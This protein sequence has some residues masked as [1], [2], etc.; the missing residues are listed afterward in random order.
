M[1]LTLDS[2]ILLDATG[3]GER[4]AAMAVDVVDRASRSD[5]VQTLQSFSEMFRVLTARRSLTA[6][7]AI[8]TKRNLRTLFALVATN[9]SDFRAATGAVRDHRLSFRDTMLWATARR[10]GC[11]V[12]RTEDSQAGRSL[13]GVRF[14]HPF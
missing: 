6:D 13:G 9:A 8:E 11:R 3:Q 14:V 1:R 2:N 5:C 10:T 7:Q 12:I 4:R